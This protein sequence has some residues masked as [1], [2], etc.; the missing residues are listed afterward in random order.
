MK[1]QVYTSAQIAQHTQLSLDLQKSNAAAS[2]IL[3][4]LGRMSLQHNRFKALSDELASL[5]R[6]MTLQIYW[7]EQIAGSWVREH[8][9]A[10]VTVFGVACDVCFK[11]GLTR[12]HQINKPYETALEPNEAWAIQVEGLFGLTISVAH[13]V[14][15]T[16]FPSRRKVEQSLCSLAP[17]SKVLLR[18]R[19]HLHQISVPQPPKIT[20]IELPS[21]VCGVCGTHLLRRG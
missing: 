8:P 2:H 11:S 13:K 18:Q 12:T 19:R 20:V 6:S 21:S 1:S 14:S 16:S 15:Q 5:V 17:L 7:C 4:Q 10:E 9:E 3:L